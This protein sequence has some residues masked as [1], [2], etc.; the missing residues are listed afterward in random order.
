MT[1]II[2]IEYETCQYY[3]LYFIS[4]D[5]EKDKKVPIYASENGV[6]LCVHQFLQNEIYNK[7]LFYENFNYE[8][9]KLFL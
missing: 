5:I 4:Y 6:K 7:L 9:N 2:Y 1:Y 8:Y 3:E